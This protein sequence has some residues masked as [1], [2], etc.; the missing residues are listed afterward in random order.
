MIYE[1][2]EGFDFGGCACISKWT[3]RKE[4]EKELKRLLSNAS[5]FASYTISEKKK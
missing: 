2:W 1:V 3:T 5:I 4:A